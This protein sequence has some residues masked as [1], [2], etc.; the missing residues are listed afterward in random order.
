MNYE[1]HKEIDKTMCTL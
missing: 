1:Y